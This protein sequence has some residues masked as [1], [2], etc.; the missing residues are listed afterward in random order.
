V[1]RRRRSTEV[2][3]PSTGVVAASS[4][5]MLRTSNLLPARKLSSGITAP[6][7]PTAAGGPADARNRRCLEPN[8]ISTSSTTTAPG[9]SAAPGSALPRAQLRRHHQ[10]S[11]RPATRLPCRAAVQQRRQ[12][13][14][15]NA[16]TRVVQRFDR[17]S[18]DVG[19]IYAVGETGAF[20]PAFALPASDYAPTG[21]AVP[22]RIHGTTIGVLAI[23]GLSSDQDHDLAIAALRSESAAKTQARSDRRCSRYGLR[24][25]CRSARPAIPPGRPPDTDSLR[26][27]TLDV[28]SRFR[29]TMRPARVQLVENAR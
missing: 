8:L 17:A 3:T 7:R 15:C 6:E 27:E 12:R 26:R 2:R 22:I 28:F 4:C 29:L 9:S 21:G 20:H 11:H 18:Q 1:T 5:W 10:Y 25:P 14:L 24:R 13:R 19:R 23:S 16:E